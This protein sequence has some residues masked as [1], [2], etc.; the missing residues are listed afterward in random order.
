MNLALQKSQI[1]MQKAQLLLQA[2]Q[3]VDQIASDEYWREYQSKYQATMDT[4]LA[5]QAGLDRAEKVRQAEWER[6]KE[7]IEAALAR[8]PKQGGWTFPVREYAPVQEA[9]TGPSPAL[10]EPGAEGW[11]SGAGEGWQ[12]AL[13]YPGAGA[14]EAYSYPGTEP[15]YQYAT[16]YLGGV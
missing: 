4:Y 10:T 15:E 3:R 9:P 16:G 5:Q 8:E 14:G 6:A 12:A 1:E 11:Q 13:T 7:Q 2:R